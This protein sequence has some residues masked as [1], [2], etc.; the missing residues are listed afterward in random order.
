VCDLV[1]VV[2]ERRLGGN[3]LDLPD[4]LS[5]AASRARLAQL[6]LPRVNQRV[7]NLADEATS[8]PLRFV[9]RSTVL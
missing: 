9:A 3:Q 7:G 1:R 8:H 5:G 2:D 4:R 6:A